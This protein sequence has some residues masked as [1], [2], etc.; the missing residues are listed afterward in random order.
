MVAKPL[1]HKQIQ[2][3]E[4]TDKRQKKSCGDSLFLVVE[5]KH[6]SKNGKSFIGVMR[7]PPTKNGKQIEVRIGK[8]G[9]G[10]NEWSLKQAKDEW[11]KIKTLSKEKGID[12]RVLRKAD[13]PDY[14]QGLDTITIG[15]A[16]D[17]FYEVNTTY[18]LS[19]EKVWGRSTAADYKNRIYNQILNPSDGGFKRDTPIKD[20]E[21]V[22]GGRKKLFDMREN[23]QKRGSLRQA[24]RNFGVCK[25]IFEYAIDR[26]WL[27]EP[28]PAKSSQETRSKLT[29]K[30][31]PH[32]KWEELDKLCSDINENRNNSQP[33]VVQATKFV[34]LTAMRVGT[35]APLEWKELNEKENVWCIP[36]EKMKYQR[37]EDFYVPMTKQMWSIVE[38]MRPITGN[39]DY[40]FY[41]PRSK[42]KH[43][44]P[45]SINAFLKRLGYADRLTGH[46]IRGTVLTANED[47]L[48]FEKNIV[49]IQMSHK[50]M[51]SV[52]RAYNHATYW[53]KRVEFME[54]WS[55]EMEKKGLLV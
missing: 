44:N 27:M 10:L 30:H 3:L 37:N 14:K 36:Y 6:K 46:G 52:E 15:Y 11:L 54:T 43:L 47:V 13:Q 2:A 38:T 28:N 21:W 23:I 55:E 18:G 41:S 34:L 31:N 50:V 53:K 4:P 9:N 48:K 1:N 35:V 20:F 12:P 24:D 16:C 49:R 32:L 45:S 8:F 42:N 51:D 40:V 19:K 29:V 22:N 26:G 25:R 17:K 39:T 33:E 5:P 7:F